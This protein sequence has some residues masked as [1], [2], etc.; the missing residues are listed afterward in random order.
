ME[1]RQPSNDFWSIADRICQKQC[2]CVPEYVPV[3]LCLCAKKAA[4]VAVNQFTKAEHRLNN[5]K[6]FC[7]ISVQCLAS[8]YYI[9]RL[10]TYFFWGGVKVVIFLNFRHFFPKISTYCPTLSPSSSGGASDD[11]NQYTLCFVVIPLII[12]GLMLM[13][14]LHNSVQH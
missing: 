12:N 14:V 13:N 9:T 4:G 11:N 10:I 6:H 1:G 8:L 3:S 5:S 7:P 2:A